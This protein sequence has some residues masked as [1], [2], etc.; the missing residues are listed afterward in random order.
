MRPQTALLSADVN[1]EVPTLWSVQPVLVRKFIWLEG[2]HLGSP[3]C[4]LVPG[5]PMGFSPLPP[6]YTS[7]DPIDLGFGLRPWFRSS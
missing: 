1:L 5:I 2:T 3:F 4:S 6:S 7:R